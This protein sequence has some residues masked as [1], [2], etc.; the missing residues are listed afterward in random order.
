MLSP[1][2]AP[3]TPRLG[4]LAG[5]PLARL[6]IDSPLGRIAL[7]AEAD[8]LVGA[9]LPAQAAQAAREA[10]GGAAA[11]S[12]ARAVLAQAAAQLA[13]YFA[14]AR[15][16]LDVPLA[17]RGTA[18]QRLVWAQLA[19]I[20]YGETRSYGELAR[21]LGRPAASRAVGAANGRNPIS[22]FLPCHRVIASSGELTGYAGG[23]PA[24]AWL[25]A[26]EARAAPAA[27]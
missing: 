8:A 27:R 23:L 25:L 9:Y 24:K 7:H 18:F 1:V 6:E 11:P 26:H 22:I 12:S 15:R 14:G 3:P 5:R 17:P 20:P 21:A 4:A 19:R 10:P 2:T 13:E 16:E